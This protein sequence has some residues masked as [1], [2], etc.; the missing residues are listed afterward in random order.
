VRAER[1][2]AEATRRVTRRPERRGVAQRTTRVTRARTT[3]GPSVCW[4]RRVERAP[5]N[6]QPTSRPTSSRAR[7]AR[8]TTTEPAEMLIV[9]D[10]S[11]G[12]ERRDHHYGYGADHNSEDRQERAELVRVQSCERHSEALGCILLSHINFGSSID[13]S[14]C[15]AIT[16]LAELPG[17]EDTD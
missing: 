9:E 6:D 11:R 5:W 4:S 1:D 2:R 3:W 8:R 15:L 13:F 17:R 10:P 16:A 7:A 12:D 14:L